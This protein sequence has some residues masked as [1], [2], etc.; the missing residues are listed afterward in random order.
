MG[1]SWLQFTPAGALAPGISYTA[2]VA[3]ARTQSGD[4]GDFSW[5]FWT[6]GE[7]SLDPAFGDRGILMTARAVGSSLA[8]ASGGES[9]TVGRR[10]PAQGGGG[11]GAFVIKA[12]VDGA[13]DPSYLAGNVSIPF[14]TSIEFQSVARDGSGRVLVAAFNQ[15]PGAITVAR[16]D[17][18]GGLDQ[19]FGTGGLVTVP[20]PGLWVTSQRALRVLD[21]G[22]LV[23]AFGSTY[24]SPTSYA[25]IRLLAD[26]SVDPGFASA[27]VL[28]GS[29]KLVGLEVL[30]SGGLVV[31]TTSATCGA[32]LE[33]YG[34]NGAADTTFGEGGAHC[35]GALAEAMAMKLDATGR[36]LLAGSTG[37]SASALLRLTADGQPDTT[38]GSGGVATVGQAS[39]SMGLAVAADGR[40]A[41]S[42][43]HGMADLYLVGPG[44]AVSY[45]GPLP[46][47]L[48]SSLDPIA[49]DGNGRLYVAAGR[50]ARPWTD[51]VS[52]VS[53]LYDTLLFRFQ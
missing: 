31:A 20:G 11:E 29:G 43:D 4:P 51:G 45:L 15:N 37:P 52:T 17:P 6:W 16:L 30:S 26:G 8:V 40:A 18:L 24:E 25:L 19:G 21:D 50:L 27:G 39:F 12:G 1:Q 13:P 47:D 53:E 3:G 36:I 41:V 34:P 10:A 5:T 14:A 32:R 44:G 23:L 38:F 33:R 49:F 28:R 48:I 42:F 22:R 35:L 9:W 2:T 46:A 7:A